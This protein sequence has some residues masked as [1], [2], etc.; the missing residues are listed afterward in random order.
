MNELFS[1]DVRRI[2]TKTALSLA[3]EV[4]TPSEVVVDEP[5]ESEHDDE[6]EERWDII[7][8]C[9]NSQCGTSALDRV[10]SLCQSIS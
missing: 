1:L 7:D 6:E 9:C 4:K 10:K 3:E 2:A 5:E 8:L